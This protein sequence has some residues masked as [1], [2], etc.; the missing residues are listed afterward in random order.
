MNI[1]KK[2]VILIILL[3]VWFMVYM[4][5]FADKKAV[6]FDKQRAN[7]LEQLED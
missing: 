3:V 6:E 7:R 1:P 5:Q 4:M 2:L